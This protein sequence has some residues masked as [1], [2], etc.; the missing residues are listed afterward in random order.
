MSEHTSR[1]NSLLWVTWTLPMLVA[2]AGCSQSSLKTE[3]TGTDGTTGGD[4]GGGGPGT[5]TDPRT[6]AG[7]DPGC[8]DFDGVAI[9][10]ATGYFYGEYRATADPDVWEGVEQWILY[11]NAEWRTYGEDDCVVTWVATAARSDSAGTCST[12]AYG[13]TIEAS[14]DIASTTCPEALY[15]GDEQFS[16]VYGVAVSGETSTWYFAQSGTQ[17]ATGFATEGAANFLSE[18]SCLYF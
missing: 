12:C 1:C 18:G 4:D 6:S 9:P 10:G 8:E 2:I 3:D 14:L 17:F 7:A 16:A 5:L 15:A 13:L 11:S